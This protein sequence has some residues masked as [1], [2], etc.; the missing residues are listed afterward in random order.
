MFWIIYTICAVLVY[1]TSRFA[2]RSGKNPWKWSLIAKVV[3]VVIALTPILNVGLGFISIIL[4]A[5]HL[6]DKDNISDRWKK[7]QKW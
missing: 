4:W 1:L 7:E 2:S 6:S 3:T 5:V